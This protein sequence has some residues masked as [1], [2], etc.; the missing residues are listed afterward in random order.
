[1]ATYQEQIEKL[2]QQ[3]EERELREKTRKI[4]EDFTKRLA[5]GMIFGPR[6]AALLPKE[7]VDELFRLLQ[8]E[9][10]KLKERPPL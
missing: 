9:L 5:L 8:E 4:A 6:L 10:Q 7:E 1:M 3:R 2:R